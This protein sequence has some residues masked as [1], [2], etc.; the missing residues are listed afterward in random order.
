MCLDSKTGFYGILVWQWFQ[1]TD[2]I[3]KEGIK[4]DID[5]LM[6]SPL[7]LLLVGNILACVVNI[8][9]E[10]S[11]EDYTPK[12]TMNLHKPID[13]HSQFL[14]DCY[15]W[16]GGDEVNNLPVGKPQEE[17]MMNIATS[18]SLSKKPRFNRSSRKKP[19]L[20]KVML[21]SFAT[22]PDNL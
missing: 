12:L 4:S 9:L 21:A 20:Q 5:A 14:A 6:L 22:A 10:S 13:P 7:L 3:N 19:I 2:Q 11:R 16:R 1:N 8:Y 15:R 17:G 18:F